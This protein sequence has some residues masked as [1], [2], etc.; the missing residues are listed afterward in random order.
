VGLD[1]HSIKFLQKVSKEIELKSVLT[2]GR[3]NIVI[4]NSLLKEHLKTD[5][6]VVNDFA[7]N[8][9]KEMFGAILVSSIDVT[10][11]QGCDI[12][13]DMNLPIG[14]E[15]YDKFDT[16]ID[17]GT[18]EHIFNVPTALENISA[19]VKYGG[20]IIHFAPANNFCGHGFYQFSPEFFFQYY[21]EPFYSIEEMVIVDTAYPSGW[22]KVTRPE[23]G[24]RLNIRS[25]TSLY[26][27]CLIKKIS[28]PPKGY[29]IQ[30]SDYIAAWDGVNQGV[31]STNHKDEYTNTN[32]L[33][34]LSKK[35]G[36]YKIIRFFGSIFL[37]SKSKIGKSHPFL[38]WEK[39]HN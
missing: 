29:T 25:S 19:L 1:L 30:Q 23:S 36:V 15:L 27:Y 12:I 8:L 13:S 6:Y 17:G 38:K 18:L 10:D 2:L 26:V 28:N 21:A 14:T 37:S 16:V 33:V 3:Q 24:I 4:S 7:E 20:H 39:F 22:Y 32:S 34:D 31:D 9:I 11:Y 5:K 35:I